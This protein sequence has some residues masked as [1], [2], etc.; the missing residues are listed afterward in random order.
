MSNHD[1]GSV[2][3]SDSFSKKTH[4]MTVVLPTLEATFVV[5]PGTRNVAHLFQ[6]PAQALLRCLLE[7]TTATDRTFVMAAAAEQEQEAVVTGTVVVL[8]RVVQD[9]R[10]PERFSVVVRGLHVRNIVAL[11]YLIRGSFRG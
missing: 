4:T 1:I 3:P 7:R 2:P 5:Y 9:E 10:R 8:E 6:P 11:S